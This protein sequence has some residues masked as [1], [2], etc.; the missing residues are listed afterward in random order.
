VVTNAAGCGVTSNTAT[1]RIGSSVGPNIVRNP[2]SLVVVAP[3]AAAFSVTSGGGRAGT[4]LT[5]NFQWRKNGVNLTNAAPNIW[6]AAVAVNVNNSSLQAEATSTLN[7]SPSSVAG[8]PGSY[9]CVI[10]TVG[11]TVTSAA[12]T[13]SVRQYTPATAVS[14]TP[15][16]ALPVPSGTPVLFTAVGSGSVDGVTLTLAPAGAYQ[17]QFWIYWNSSLGWTMVQDYGVGSTYTL[18]GSVPAGNYGI[19]VDCRTSP[20]VAWDTFNAIDFFDLTSISGPAP[21]R[22]QTTLQPGPRP[23][24]AQ[25]H[26]IRKK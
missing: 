2:S 21:S 25:V 6:N 26:P 18:P 15:T 19:G 11:G 13:L 16:P 12:A 8:S 4:S 20:A 3:S 1:V 17:Y 10:T 22:I 7:I 9:D 23:T 24:F 14:L 5:L